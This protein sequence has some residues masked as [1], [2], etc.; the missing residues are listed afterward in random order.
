MKPPR[1]AANMACDGVSAAW[2]QF[3][4]AQAVQTFPDPQQ[5]PK[6]FHTAPNNVERI[7]DAPWNCWVEH[8]TTGTGIFVCLVRDGSQD[9]VNHIVF[10]AW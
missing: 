1:S 4:S 2:K 6:L 10:W 5:S 7:V 9:V 3:L 8:V